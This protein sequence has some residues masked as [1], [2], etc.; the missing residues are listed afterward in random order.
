M[1]RRLLVLLAT[2]LCLAEL[3]VV[4]G[5]ASADT[6]DSQISFTFTINYDA[7]W[8]YELDLHDEATLALKCP[9]ISMLP[10]RMTDSGDAQMMARQIL[11][12]RYSIT[13]VPLPFD[14]QPV[15]SRPIL[16][17]I[18]QCQ[19]HGFT[20][21]PAGNYYVS[22]NWLCPGATQ[23]LGDTEWWYGLFNVGPNTDQG[24]RKEIGG[25]TPGPYGNKA[26]WQTV[27]GTCGWNT[28]YYVNTTSLSRTYC[29]DPGFGDPQECATETADWS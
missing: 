24:W 11:E 19:Y 16:L 15:A 28:D 22:A 6:I 18:G 9:R 23:G 10:I 27:L 14:G 29:F 21:V 7:R 1:R 5:I 12:P 17:T 20:D 13:R 26:G 3:A 4:P 8:D 2:A 25:E